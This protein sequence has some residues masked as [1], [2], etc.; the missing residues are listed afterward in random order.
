VSRL[1]AVG[2]ALSL[3]F[4]VACRPASALPDLGPAPEFSLVDQRGADFRSSD[5][6]GK[7]VV[8]NFIFTT[9]TDICPLL[10]GTM[11][12]LQS[13]LDQ[14]GLLGSKA[15]LISI[16]VDPQR[17]T[18]EALAEYAE[19]FG[20]DYAKWRFLT[21]DAAQIESLLVTGYKIGAPFRGPPG[22]DGQAQLAHSNRFVVI[23]P[24]GRIRAYP[25]GDE[26]DVDQ[27]VEEVRRLAA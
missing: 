11:A 7:V 15:M 21:G 2:L 27:I 18:P 9:C 20:A 22:P 16:S 24:A 5:L 26:L 1:L 25:R 23:D 3:A 10:T 13:R 4:A 17:D 8:G 12:Q 14:A 19:R 6:A